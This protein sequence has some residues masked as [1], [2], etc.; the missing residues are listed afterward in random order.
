[1]ASQEI[2]QLPDAKPRFFYGY[3]VVGVAFIIMVLSWGTFFS[4]GVFLN[5]Y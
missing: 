1:M 3:I 5:R 2:Q 4:F